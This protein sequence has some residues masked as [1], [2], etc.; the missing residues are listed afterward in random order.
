MRRRSTHTWPL[1]LRGQPRQPI[2]AQPFSNMRVLY[3]SQ[4]GM[5]EPLGQSQV[6]PY[7]TGLARAGYGIE[8]V[9]FEPEEARDEAIARVRQQLGDHGIG[10]VWLR[11]SRAHDVATK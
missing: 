1:E 8:L 10:Y 5:T 7:L 2:A 9:T 4:T 6:I 11:R 3:V